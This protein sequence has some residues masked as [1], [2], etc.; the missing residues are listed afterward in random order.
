[1]KTAWGMWHTLADIGEHVGERGFNTDKESNAGGNEV[2]ELLT[3]LGKSGLDVVLLASM[4]RSLRDVANIMRMGFADKVAT[5]QEEAWLQRRVPKHGEPP[6]VVKG[7][8][9][10]EKA[11]LVRDVVNHSTYSNPQWY[12]L[13]EV[14]DK[15][16]PFRPAYDKW[17]RKKVSKK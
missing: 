13:I 2:V 7:W 8:L 5:D 10:M 9:M 11:M 14:P 3:G 16:S 15:D 1:M 6:T 12:R 4:E 17:M